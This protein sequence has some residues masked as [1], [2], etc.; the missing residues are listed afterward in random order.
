M[1]AWIEMFCI[2]YLS[3]SVPVAPHVGA[4]IEITICDQAALFPL[5]LPTWERGLKFPTLYLLS[6][7]QD[8]APHVG[9][10][11]EIY[12]FHTSLIKVMSLPPWER[13]L[14]WA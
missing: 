2:A 7:A 11:I 9:A 5:S 3:Y 8:V 1:G 6:S 14:K 10:W 4:W 12:Y 13:G